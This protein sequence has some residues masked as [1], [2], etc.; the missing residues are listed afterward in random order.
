[1]LPAPTEI[2]ANGNSPETSGHSLVSWKAVSG[3]NRY[4]VRYLLPVLV[5]GLRVWIESSIVNSTSVRLTGLGLDKFHELRVQALGNSIQS[6]WSKPIYTYPTHDPATKGTVV[7]ILTI[8]GYRNTPVFVGNIIS[9]NIIGDYSYVLCTNIEDDP[10]TVD[11]DESRTITSSEQD[12]IKEGVGIWKSDTGMVTYDQTSKSCSGSELETELK[13]RPYKNFIRMINDSE[14]RLMCGSVAC[15]D[16]KQIVN[17]EFR[18]SQIFIKHN[19]S[20]ADP[21]GIG[22][23]ELYQLSMHEAGHAYGLADYQHGDES[24]TIAPTVM[25]NALYDNCE[26]TEY[27]I[28]AIKAIYQSHP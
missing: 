8:A 13:D 27:D 23:S 5:T 26:P 24:Y 4:K 6:K 14:L 7:G 3:A 10:L 28:V 20:T 2:T 1:M 11:I 21:D 18:I 22:C 9:G 17:D 12:I 25:S 15:I 16:H 19:A